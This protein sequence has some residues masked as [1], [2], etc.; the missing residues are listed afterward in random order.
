MM[1]DLHTVAA[2][3]AGASS[4]IITQQNGRIERII[5]MKYPYE[6]INENEKISNNTALLDLKI[7]ENL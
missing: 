2:C 1:E 7:K 4:K 3:G 5:N 6:Y